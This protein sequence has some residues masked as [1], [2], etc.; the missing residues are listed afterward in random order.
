VARQPPAPR[1]F[2]VE[3]LEG[4]AALARSEL[5][6]MGARVLRTGPDGLRVV[7]PGAP[8]RLLQLRLASAVYRRL[9]FDVPRPKALLGDSHFRRLAAAVREVAGSGPVF[10]GFRFAAAGVDSPVF[11]RLGRALAEAC[12]VPF[13]PQAGEL[14][15]RVRKAAPDGGWEV[16]VRLTPRPLSARPWRVCNRPGGLNATLAVAMN[17][18]AG[19]GARDRYLNLMCGSGT[20]LVER[21]L[22]GP[23]KELV[24][25]DEDAGAVACAEANLAAAG[26]SAACRLLRADALAAPLPEAAFDVIT[27]DLP[28]GDAVG[29]HQDNRA[30]HPAVLDA[31]ARLAAPG[32]RLVLLT[33]ELR[34][35][36]AV[37]R[38]QHRWRLERELKVAHGGHFPHV[39]LL[40]P[41]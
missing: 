6:A 9:S 12:G 5:E 21:S 34:L 14:L 41:G 31:A 20:L 37:L 8:A 38:Q 1:E 4:L 39:Y 32:A 17:R 7:A 15:L 26:A 23:A 29:S 10:R 27:A 24:G 40:R 3:V 11:L 30:L 13:D 33:H 28:W 22:D 18:L 2:E 19:S 25:L 35:F 16:L 36:Q